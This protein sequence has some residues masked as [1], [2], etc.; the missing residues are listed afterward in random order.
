MPQQIPTHDLRRFR[1]AA[2]PYLVK[3]QTAGSKEEPFVSNIKDISAGG[4]RF[5]T[6]S[7]FTEKTLLK[8]KICLPPLERVIEI[9][10]RIVRVRKAQGAGIYHLAVSF[11]EMPRDDQD[12]LN[13]FIEG[14]LCAWK[15]KES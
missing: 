2:I 15:K 5:W 7:V 10:G 6:D 13:Q 11:V 4:L 14:R 9:L 3:F 1:R 8:I 12:T